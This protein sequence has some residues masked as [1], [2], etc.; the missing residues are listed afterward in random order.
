MSCVPQSGIM[1]KRDMQDA[2]Y[3]FLVTL[4]RFK[5]GENTGEIYNKDICE[6]IVGYIKK[7]GSCEP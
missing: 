5:V 7:K 4:L 2:T 6:F 1:N 3:H